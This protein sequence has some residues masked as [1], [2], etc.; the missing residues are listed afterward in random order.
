MQRMV[1]DGVLAV[2]HGRNV[3]DLDVLLNVLPDV[4]ID[5]AVA[6]RFAQ[7]T[8]A[9]A[10]TQRGIP[11]A[12]RVNQWSTAS[13]AVAA[14]RAAVLDGPLAVDAPSRF[15]STLSLSQ[16][17]VERDTSGNVKLRKGHRR[18]RDDVAQAV[19]WACDGAAKWR[20]AA[21]AGPPRL[22]FV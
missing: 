3:A 13:E 12:W 14:F 5:H 21:S 11:V 2:A 18:R 15:L 8:L 10:L 20:A 9:E 19:L 4:Q 17:E 22:A 6:D 1:D 7:W 16:A